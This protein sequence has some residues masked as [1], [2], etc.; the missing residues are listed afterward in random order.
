MTY[1]DILNYKE[2]YFE[3]KT[4]TKVNGLPTI[5][6]ILEVFRQLKRNAQSVPTTLGG[7]QFGYLFLVLKPVTYAAIQ[8]AVNIQRP[9]D[10]GPFTVTQN[11][12]PLATRA[13]PNP[14]PPPLSASDIAVQKANWE[15]RKRLYH[16]VQAVELVLRNQLTEAFDPEYLQALRDP[17]TDMLTGS[18]PDI[19][20][21][22]ITTYG[23]LTDNDMI[24]REQNLTALT[25]NTAQPVDIIFNAIDKFADLCDIQ[26]DPLTDRRKCQF[27][28]VIFQK[29]RAFLDSLKKWNAK[30]QATKSYQ[31]MKTFMREE[32]SA[33]EAVGALSIKESLNQVKLLQALQEHFSCSL[34][35]IKTYRR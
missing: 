22:L 31:N 14:V 5:D 29:S 27:A 9:T 1:S 3:K 23:K 21:F 28:Y 20:S 6:T 24:T 30:P 4:L 12:A 15:E 33:L 13:N 11:P 7:G 16:E 18:I 25:Y 34:S 8:G 17:T 19:I 26:G 2:R 32:K 10:P 35:L